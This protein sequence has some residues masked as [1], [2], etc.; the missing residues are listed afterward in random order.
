MRR[1]RRRD[2]SR[3][4]ARNVAGHRDHA[5]AALADKQARG[6]GDGAGVA[7]ARALSDNA[8]AIAE[9]K[10]FR[11]RIDGDD[12]HAGELTGPAQRLEHVLEHDARERATLLGAHARREPL[13]GA[14]EFLDRHDRPDV[15]HATR[16]R[17]RF[18]PPSAS[19]ASSTTRASSSFSA[20]LV[21]NV[22]ASVTFAAT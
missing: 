10:R 16:S 11:D 9:A 6:G 18:E 8:R 5:R 17:P 4:R 13:L 21:I 15:G 19:A 3:R 1:E 12:K 20:R 2:L 22:A 7:F 14:R